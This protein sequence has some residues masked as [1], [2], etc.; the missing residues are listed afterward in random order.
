MYSKFIGWIKV[1]TESIKAIWDCKKWSNYK[2]TNTQNAIKKGRKSI[3]SKIQKNV[4]IVEKDGW[5]RPK[6][7]N[8]LKKKK[9]KVVNL[10]CSKFFM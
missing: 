7:E 9:R 1:I 8:L 3:W 10:S 5:R 2:V 4:P 6:Y